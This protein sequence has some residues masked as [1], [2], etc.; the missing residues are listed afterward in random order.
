MRRTGPDV[1]PARPKMSRDFES[2]LSLR[3]LARFRGNVSEAEIQ[4]FSESIIWSFLSY[5]ISYID[6]SPDF[7]YKLIRYLFIGL[8]MTGIL[9]QIV[10][11]VVGSGSTLRYF[12][13]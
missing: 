2:F 7:M 3:L 10:S 8:L 5:M 1:G 4:K 9:Y 6:Y 12:Y 11:A 13:I